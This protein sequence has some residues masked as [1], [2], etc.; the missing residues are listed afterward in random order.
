MTIPLH[1]SEV[2]SEVWYAGTDREIRGKTL[3]DVV[4]AGLPVHERT[5]VSWLLSPQPVS[6][7]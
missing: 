4:V 1:I 5:A 2:P 3:C 6:G 7:V